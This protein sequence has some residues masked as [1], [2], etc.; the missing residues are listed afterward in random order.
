MR[1]LYRTSVQEFQAENPEEPINNWVEQMTDGEI[2]DFL[3]DGT[4]D[5]STIMMLINAIYFKG[6]WKTPFDEDATMTADF[7]VSETETADV[8]M[9]FVDDDFKL[10]QSRVLNAEVLELPYKGERYAMTVILPDVSTNLRDVT[11]RLNRRTLDDILAQLKEESPRRLRL[12]MPKFALDTDQS[13][14]EMLQRL[15]I[16]HAFGDAAKFR[17]M[18]S[19]PVKISDVTHRAVIEVD[20]EGT[21]AAAATGVG[22]V[23][24]SA[25]VGPEVNV[26]RP[27]LFI[28]RDTQ[29]N[30]NLFS[31]QFVDPEGDNLAL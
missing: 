12:R 14:K 3:E 17:K 10:L 19:T 8:E 13:M 16:N 7:K 28:I 9:M 30:V 20:E 11:S 1:E 22:M 23:L 25:Y 26:D 4:I 15:G 5:D 2:E 27:F 29:E 24:L 31:G 21:V 18:T 6:K